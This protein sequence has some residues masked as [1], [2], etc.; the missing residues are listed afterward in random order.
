M[1]SS[2]IGVPA[3]FRALKADL[4]VSSERATM[5]ASQCPPTVGT[6]QHGVPA[7]HLEY[8]NTMRSLYAQGHRVMGFVQGQHPGMMPGT[9]HPAQ[10]AQL[11]PPRSRYDLRLTSFKTKFIEASSRVY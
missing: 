4:V 3:K 9:R 1:P 8:L 10:P 11:S 7:C 2:F 5:W 6:P